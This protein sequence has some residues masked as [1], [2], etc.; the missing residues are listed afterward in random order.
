YGEFVKE[1]SAE[2]KLDLADLNTSVVDALKKAKEIDEPG[3]QKLIQDRVHPGP[4]GQLLMAEALLKA[5]NAPA[6]VSS[7]EIDV[8]G[9]GPVKALNT[10]VSDFTRSG[11]TIH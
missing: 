10:K 1:L 2:H 7:V 4:G 5:W 3:S 9:N 11:G 8:L 6:L